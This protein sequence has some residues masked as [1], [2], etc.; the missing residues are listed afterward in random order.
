MNER[1]AKFCEEF[2]IDLCGKQAAIRAGYS[3][4][5]AEV[6]S[7]RLLRNA[8]IKAKI[9]ELRLKQQER[10]EITS[11]RV[12]S[13]YAK[14]A[15]TDLVG[16]VNFSGGKMSIADFGNLTASQRACIKKFKVK[17]LTEMG[18]DGEP[19]PVQ[20]VEVELHD[21]Q[22]ALD[23][24]SRHLGICNEKVQLQAEHYGAQEIVVRIVR[25][26]EN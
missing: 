19:V 24:L 7:F 25:D 17:T 14:I 18:P 8:R 10:T 20:A 21:K 9:T 2:L 22:H 26:G 13:E 23:Q 11:D 1:A 4:R 12:L 3:P 5:S 6:T 15:F 16:I